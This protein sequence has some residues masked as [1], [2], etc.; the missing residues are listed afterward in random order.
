MNRIARFEALAEW[1]VEGTFARLFAGYLHPLE[2]ATHLARAM[3]D[4]QTRAP[5]GTGLAPTHYWVYLHPQDFGPLIAHR[6]TLPEEL[7][8]HV[9][10][11]AREAGLALTA[12]PVVFVEPLLEVPPHSVRVEARQQPPEGGETGTTRE[13]TEEEQEVIQ[14]AAEEEPPGQPFLIVN[15]ER[16]VAL[17]LPVVSV[18]RALDNDVILEDPRVSRHHAQ[19]RRR[20]GRYILYDLGSSGGTMIN[21]Y[22]VQECVLQPGDVISFAGIEVIYGED[23]PAPS[24][25]PAEGD[26]S[27][28]KAGGPTDPEDEG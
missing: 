26:T 20:Y 7:A 14:A 4:H 13:M 3:E 24:P 12:P 17:T 9:A 2:V 27:A 15:G 19:L 6:P 25:E 5:D 16:H 1:L 22:P 18:G 8:D 10:E 21:G 23:P 11:L 28:L